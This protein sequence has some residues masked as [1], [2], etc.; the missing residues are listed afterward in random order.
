MRETVAVTGCGRTDTG[1]HALNQVANFRT[2]TALPLRN[3][4]LGVNSLLRRVRPKWALG[5]GE[6]IV[7][8]GML[9]VASAC[10]GLDQVQT[11]VEVVAHPFWGATPENKWDDLFLNVMPT[12]LTVTDNAALEAYFDSGLPM[13][14]TPYW[15]PWVESAPTMH[16]CTAL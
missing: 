15:K 7:V 14:S 10:C 12:W 11:M 5:H 9:S 16:S 13:F 3:L 6:L 8:Y 2:A 1:V 4:H